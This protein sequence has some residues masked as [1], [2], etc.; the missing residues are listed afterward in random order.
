[1]KLLFIARHQTYFRNY[2]SAIR[3]LVARGHRI[4]LAVERED[5]ISG[6]AA[7]AALLRDCPG[8]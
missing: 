6:A 7:V 8:R 1:M 3:A 2:D 5:Q 4:Q